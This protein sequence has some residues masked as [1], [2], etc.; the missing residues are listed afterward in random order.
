MPGVAVALLA[1]D[2]DRLSMLQNRLES[3]HAGQIVFSHFGF[4]MG[5]SDSILRQI[6]DVHA[7][8]VV[9]DIDPASGGRR[10]PSPP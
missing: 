2:R 10:E 5:P 8:V 1:E 7:E 4:P 3:T 9:V 6:Q